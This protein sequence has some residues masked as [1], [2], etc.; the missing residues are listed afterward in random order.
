MSKAGIVVNLIP[1]KIT[2]FIIMKSETQIQNPINANYS[3]EN[4]II[5]EDDNIFIVLKKL[6]SL[7]SSL[8]RTK[9]AFK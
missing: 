9:L 2:S 1:V 6:Q 8:L 7:S 3:L 4:M 5:N